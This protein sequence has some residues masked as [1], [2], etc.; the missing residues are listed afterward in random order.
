MAPYLTFNL[1]V[2]SDVAAEPAIIVDYNR[3]VFLTEAQILAIVKANGDPI[4]S[5][6]TIGTIDHIPVLNAFILS[7]DSPIHVKMRNLIVPGWLFTTTYVTG[8]QVADAN[9]NLQ[10]C[11]TP[12]QSGAT[13]PMWATSIGGSTPDGTVTWLCVQLSSANG[14]IKLNGGGI[15]AVIDG[16]IDAGPTLNALVSNIGP[17]P[18]NL[19]GMAGGT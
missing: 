19:S 5:F 17:A 11:I 3:R 10:Q 2:T 8:N 16:Q 9:G 13:T 14:A 4:G 6:S 1:R 12:G 18:A 7:A 15:L